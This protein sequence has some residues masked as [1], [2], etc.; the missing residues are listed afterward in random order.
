MKKEVVRY[1][2]G[3]DST[4]DALMA[5]A[6][7]EGRAEAAALYCNV[8]FAERPCDHCAKLYRGPAVYCSLE[9]ALADA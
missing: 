3:C 6:R 7:E 8:K 9:C 5:H 2:V 1:A 4:V